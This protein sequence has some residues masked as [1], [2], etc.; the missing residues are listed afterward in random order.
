MHD[1]MDEGSLS[2]LILIQFQ[3]AKWA[4]SLPSTQTEKSNT[5]TVKLVLVT[6]PKNIFF[7]TF[8]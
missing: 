7:D 3:N 5:S 1:S 6:S 4:D 2:K 8:P